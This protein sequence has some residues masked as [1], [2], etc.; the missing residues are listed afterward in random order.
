MPDENEL[1]MGSWAGVEIC[2]VLGLDSSGVNSIDI[3]IDAKSMVFAVVRQHVTK[4]QVEEI[5]E[6]ISKHRV[7]DEDALAFQL[8]ETK[9]A[10]KREGYTEG[11]ELA[12]AKILEA[13]GE[14]EEYSDE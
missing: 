8:A 2:K 13:L 1:A 12:H 6:I 4:R 9:A 5:M 11:A 14:P 10:G 3:H 7:L